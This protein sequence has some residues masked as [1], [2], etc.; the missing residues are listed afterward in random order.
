MALQLRVSVVCVGVS[1]A[2]TTTC[3]VW[4]S[5]LRGEGADATVELKCAERRVSH[6]ASV[7]DSLKEEQEFAD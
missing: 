3:I 6:S 4:R 1:L 2:V 5:L 7:R